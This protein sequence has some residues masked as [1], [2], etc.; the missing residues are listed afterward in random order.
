MDIENDYIQNDR[1]LEDAVKEMV[2]DI[3]DDSDDDSDYTVTMNRTSWMRM[4]DILLTGHWVKPLQQSSHQSILV[5][6]LMKRKLDLQL[7]SLL[8]REDV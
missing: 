7:L 5:P 2:I 1:I 3:G 6:I 8:E 4:T